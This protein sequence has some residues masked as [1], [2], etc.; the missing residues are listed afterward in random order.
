MM[1]QFILA[2]LKNFGVGRMVVKNEWLRRWPTQPSYCVIRK[3][4]PEMDRWLC[5]GKMWGDFVYRGRFIGL[6]E[7]VKDFNRSDWRLIHKH[8]EEALRKCDHP[9]KYRLLPAH[10]PLPPLEQFM[11]KVLFQSHC[12]FLCRRNLWL[13]NLDRFCII[14]RCNLVSYH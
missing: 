12:V 1:K 2:Q 9:F 8:E 6:V 3:V 11:L 4:E 13:M 14:L 10:I 5:R 7:F